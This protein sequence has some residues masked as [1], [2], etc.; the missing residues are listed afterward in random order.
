MTLSKWDKRMIEK[1]Q[2]VA[3]W[4]K[5]PSIKVGAVITDSYNR[6]ISEGFNGP[7]RGVEDDPDIPRE[8][9]LK[10][11]IHAELNAI[12]FAKRD[13]TGMTLYCTNHPCGPCAAVIA[14]SGITRVVSPADCALSHRWDAD[15][16]QAQHI[17]KQAH[18]QHDK[19]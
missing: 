9:K 12:L 6:A 17:F 3:S 19:Y 13:L 16:M 15:K 18:I 5:D 1:A 11:T 10:R 7:P 2:L 8:V 14:Q 4:S